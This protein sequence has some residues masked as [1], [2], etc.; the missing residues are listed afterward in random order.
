[1]EKRKLGEIE[2]SQIGMGTMAFSHGYGKIPERQYSIDAIRAA[3]DY[4]CT[5]FDTAEV[6]GAQLYYEGHNEEIVGEALKDVRG[7]AVIAT[8]F[9]FRPDEGGSGEALYAAIKGHL[10]RSMK[11]LQTDDVDLYYL[12]RI[13]SRIPVENV[14][15]A[16]GR[17]IKEGLIR[18]WGLSQVSVYTLKRADQVTPVSAVQNLYNILERDC[19]ADI[20]PYCME[21]GIGV[22]P[23]SPIAS[24]LLSG[25][26]TVN[27]EFEK[28]DD[29][30]S[31]VPQLTRENIAGNQPILDI[32][33]EYAKKKNAANAQISLAWMLHKYPN[34]VPIPGS[35]NK[36]RIL[37]NLGAD[38]VKFTD[39]EF[40][41]LETAL[42]GC[43][44]YGHRGHV[45]EEGNGFLNKKPLRM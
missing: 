15:E 38:Q 23:F 25:K 31:W 45:E 27:T 16:M 35:K 24:G 40:D 43:T 17:L 12:H 2:V 10:T 34:V 42:A 13:S 32:I 7:K 5:F 41:A 9:H 6:Y 39:E 14:A 33:E 30:R 8:K 28:V 11:R 4:G 19:E 36:E 20:F 22:V 26:I 18:G 44:I 29:V 3:F 21:R 37:E 1:M